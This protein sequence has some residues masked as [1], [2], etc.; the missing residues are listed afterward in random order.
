MGND[1][2]AVIAAGDVPA[3]QRLRLIA[4]DVD[5]EFIRIRDA[6]VA[7]HGCLLRPVIRKTLGTEPPKCS[8]FTVGWRLTFERWDLGSGC[9]PEISDRGLTVGQYDSHA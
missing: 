3:H 4:V 6:V 9:A 7:N 1:Q 8:V 5:H 2:L